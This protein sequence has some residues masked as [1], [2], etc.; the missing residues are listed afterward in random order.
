MTAEAA[1]DAPAASSDISQEEVSALLEQS[2]A[3]GVRPFDF[4]AQRINRTQ[5][6][7]LQV[8]GKTFAERAKVTLSALL[9]REVACE[10][11]SIDSVKPADLTA[12]TERDQVVLTWKEVPGAKGYHVYR[13]DA[14]EPWKLVFARLGRTERT[15]Y[16]DRDL[17]SSKE[18]FDGLDDVSIDPEMVQLATQLV[19]RQAGKY[20]SADIEDRYETRLREMIDAKLKGEGIDV[21]ADVPVEAT[22]NVVDL[23]AALKNSL[24]QSPAEA[25]SKGKKA[26]DVRQITQKPPIK[27][28]K[29]MAAKDPSQAATRSARK[30]A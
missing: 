5:L 3:G 18:L 4:G 16:E 19:Q 13:A 2:A 22:S 21:E 7:M 9:N 29:S 11:T 12:S 8:I 1:E 30:R 27:G 17:N 28:G 15:T 20:E 26:A 24:G 10:F 23:M 14:V 25:T 6:P